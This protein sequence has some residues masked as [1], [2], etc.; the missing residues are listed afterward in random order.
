MENEPLAQGQLKEHLM[1]DP[2]FRRLA[3]LQAKVKPHHGQHFT[4]TLTTIS[5]A[6][7]I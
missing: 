2:D 5:R 7:R 3:E 6:G 1:Q 4:Q